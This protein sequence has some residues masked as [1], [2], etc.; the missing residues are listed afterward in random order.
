M[1]TQKGPIC[2]PQ[3]LENKKKKRKEEEK[4]THLDHAS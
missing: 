3:W 1:F 2:K 4:H